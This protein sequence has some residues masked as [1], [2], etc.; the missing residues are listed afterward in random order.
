[1]GLGH[2]LQRD[3]DQRSPHRQLRRHHDQSLRTARNLAEEDRD[4]EVMVVTVDRML[5]VE[6]KRV[7][8]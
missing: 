7:W 6:A 2:R 4:L 3:Q 8:D 1:M 5:V